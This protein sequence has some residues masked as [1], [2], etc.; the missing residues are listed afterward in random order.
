MGDRNASNGSHT[1]GGE[2]DLLSKLQTQSQRMKSKMESLDVRLKQEMST[3][4]SPM[5]MT[6]GSNAG[7]HSFYA[8]P[9]FVAMVSD[10]AASMSATPTFNQTRA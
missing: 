1:W 8:N 10:A 3:L 7:V 5:P 6:E 2:R 4:N 9:R